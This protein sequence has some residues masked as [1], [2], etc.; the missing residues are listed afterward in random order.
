MTIR[1]GMRTPA[2]W[3]KELLESGSKGMKIWPFDKYSVRSMGQT[4]SREEIEAGLEPVRSIREAVGE[5]FRIGIEMHFRWNRMAAEQIG[6]A[7]EPHNIYFIED[8]L[9]AVDFQEIKRLSQALKIPIVGSEL[10]LSRWQLRDWM[11]EGVSQILNTD[12]AWTGGI[13]ETVRISAMAEAFGLPIMLHNAG[14]P[15]A[16]MASLHAAAHIPNLFELESVRAFYQTYFRELT[17]IE[18]TV[19]DGCLS[20]PPERPGLG[21]D[22]QPDI[23]QRPDVNIAVSDG[24][25]KA[26][27]LTSLGDSWSRKDIRL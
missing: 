5:D 11:I 13:A 10:L 12:L 16:H 25:G 18:V 6:Y 24:D 9:P 22:L 17:D 14:G 20:L 3:L 21:I 15:I 7:L 4:I 2:A 19:E 8:A 23:R 1:A 27:G 26:V